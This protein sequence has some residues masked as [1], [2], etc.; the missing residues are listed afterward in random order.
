MCEHFPKA[1]HTHTKESVMTEPLALLHHRY[2]HRL[3]Q[4]VKNMLPKLHQSPSFQQRGSSF[5]WLVSSE[6]QLHVDV[7]TTVQWS[8]GLPCVP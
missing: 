5:S 3:S 7:R 4:R 6:H 8:V 1:T 2:P